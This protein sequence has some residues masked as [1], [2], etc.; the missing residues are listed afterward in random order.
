MCAISSNEYK[1]KYAESFAA[2]F[3]MPED[4]LRVQIDSL[5]PGDGELTFDDVLKIAYYSSKE[6]GKYKPE[7]RRRELGF[8]YT[9][10]LMMAFAMWQDIL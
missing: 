8:S 10:L 1:E 3:L 5:H 7:K 9:K 4:E 2:S 6:L